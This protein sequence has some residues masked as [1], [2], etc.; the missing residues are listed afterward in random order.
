[1]FVRDLACLTGLNGVMRKSI[2]KPFVFVHQ[3]RVK[4]L[5]AKLAQLVLQWGVS[6]E[7]SSSL[8]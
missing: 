1:M 6:L 2:F 5:I 7:V 3:D 4:D 8:V